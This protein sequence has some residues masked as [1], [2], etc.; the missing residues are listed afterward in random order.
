M[1]TLITKTTDSQTAIGMGM[2]G[3]NYVY[4]TTGS[5]NDKGLFY[6]TSTSNMNTPVKVF[7]TEGL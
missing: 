4:P 3:S 6:G 7:G 2:K 1:L 5:L